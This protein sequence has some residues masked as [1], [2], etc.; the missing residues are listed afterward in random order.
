MNL[1]I[2]KH[3]GVQAAAGLLLGTVLMLGGGVQ[4]QA[5]PPADPVE[6]QTRSSYMVTVE[7]P[8]AAVYA[9]ADTDRAPIARVRRGQTYEVLSR[10]EGGWVGI[11]VD[12]KEGYL[13]TAGQATLMEKSSETV[14][15]EARQRRKIAEYALR[16][17]GGTYVYGGTDPHKGVDCSGFT[18]YI[19][20]KMA[21]VSLPHSAAGQSGCGSKIAGDEVQPGDLIFYQNSAGSINHV[22]MYIGKG[23][24]V[25]ASTE[26]AGIKVSPYNYRKPACYVSVL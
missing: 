1:Q 2:L 23:Q 25:H 20:E 11:R 16:F 22:A 4:A 18:R 5:A 14:N 12:G 9:A 15:S 8:E 17:V 10:E 13:K 6:V 26:S 7:A 3:R 24:V 21:E 19:L